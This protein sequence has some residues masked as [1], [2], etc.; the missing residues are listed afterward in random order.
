MQCVQSLVGVPSASCSAMAWYPW[1]TR[2]LQG[3]FLATGD[4][5]GRVMV[6][7][8]SSG[9][10][11]AI[12]EDICRANFGPTESMVKVEGRS[13]GGVADL[14]WTTAQNYLSIL[15]TT[16][17]LAVWDPASEFQSLSHCFES[18]N[19]GELTSPF[20]RW[21]ISFERPSNP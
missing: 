12:L 6:W 10:P 19:G 15:L 7:E 1:G 3:T 16:G 17:L 21:A 14:A 18:F 4:S 13:N 2:G 5:E 11:V 8:I 20:P 9:K